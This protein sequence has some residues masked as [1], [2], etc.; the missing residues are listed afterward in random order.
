MN[1]DDK[2]K[3]TYDI[4]LKTWLNE[5]ELMVYVSLGRDKIREARQKGRLG[6]LNVMG[7]IIYERATVDSWIKA[8]AKRAN[9]IKRK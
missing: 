2:I 5:K 1:L 7:R 9:T 4:S 8:E 3:P 6:S